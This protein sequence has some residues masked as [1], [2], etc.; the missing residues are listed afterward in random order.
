LLFF[1]QNRRKLKESPLTPHLLHSWV[2]FV[3]VW[4]EIVARA[5]IVQVSLDFIS[6]AHQS[7]S[8]PWILVYYS[9]S[10]KLLDG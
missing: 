4:S 10:S 5:K 7:K 9:W 6:W 8:S 1:D 2:I 3:G